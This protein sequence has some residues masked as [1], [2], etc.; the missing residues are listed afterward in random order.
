[1]HLLDEDH[2]FYNGGVTGRTDEKGRF[3]LA[4]TESGTWVVAAT[5][6]GHR[7]ARSS[8]VVVPAKDDPLV[9][10]LMAGG[11]LEVVVR[12]P[13]GQPAA[14]ISVHVELAPAT[15][16]RE[17]ETDTNGHVRFD[18]LP[19]GERNVRVRGQDWSL[20]RS[21]SISVAGTRRVELTVPRGL[22][23]LSVRLLRQGRGEPERTVFLATGVEAGGMQARTAITDAE[24]RCRFEGIPSGPVLVAF[25]DRQGGR[26][27]LRAM[28]LAPGENRAEIQIPGGS[29]RLLVVDALTAKPVA[30]AQIRGPG[31]YSR[32]GPDGRAAL[33]ELDPKP[34]R[35]TVYSDRH[36]P[37]RLRVTPSSDAEPERVALHPAVT[38]IVRARGPTGELVAGAEVVI[39]DDLGLDIGA[40]ARDLGFADELSGRAVFRLAPGRYRVRVG[41]EGFRP[42]ERS[43][44]LDRDGAQVAVTLK[45]R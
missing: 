15:G 45:A 9:L 30:G 34:T 16:V 22:A 24:G 33:A 13:D 29:V 32:T 36:G 8:D 6:E 44:R 40:Y 27:R 41:A 42:A 4:G 5:A 2:A 17:A 26:R 18:R 31:L 39:E 3:R 43:I 10:R 35:I 38:L 20:V 19:P 12:R 11:S 37:V 1:M 7:P 28:D 14:G 21:V 23:A 25:V